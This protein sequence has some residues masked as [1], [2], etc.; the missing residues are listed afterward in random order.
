MSKKRQKR[1]G[2]GALPRGVRRNL[3]WIIAGAIAVVAG[4]VVLFLVLS[5]GSSSDD[6]AGAQATP[7][8]DPRV[9]GATPAATVTVEADDDGQQVNPRFVPNVLEGPAGEVIAIDITNAGTVA[10]NLRVSGVDKQYDTA[11]DFASL[12]VQPGKEQGML[13]RID[14]PGSYPFRCDFHP[15]QVGTLAVN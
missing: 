8:P 6:T 14:T 15:Q 12:T 2:S 5:G 9:A 10:H 3:G 11:D 1:G 7:R 13:V 4:M